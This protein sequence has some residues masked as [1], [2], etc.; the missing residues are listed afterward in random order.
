MYMYKYKYMYVYAFIYIYM[1]IYVDT[2]VYVCMKQSTRRVYL[3]GRSSSGVDP[4]NFFR[5]ARVGILQVVQINKQ[6]D[7]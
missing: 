5:P 7:K 6:I 1:N 2:Y 4:V 3:F